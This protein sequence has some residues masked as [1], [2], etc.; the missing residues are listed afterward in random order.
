MIRPS[1]HCCSR[2]ITGYLNLAQAS[3]ESGSV[4]D[5]RLV[6]ENVSNLLPELSERDRRH[7][8]EASSDSPGQI[9]PRANSASNRRNH[10]SSHSDFRDVTSCRCFRPGQRLDKREATCCG[11]GSGA[12][13]GSREPAGPASDAAAP[14]LVTS[15]MGRSKTTC[16]CAS[17]PVT[18]TTSRTARSSSTRNAAVTAG[19]RPGRAALAHRTSQP[20]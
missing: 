11:G 13:P 6:L 8:S 5:T 19:A 1:M 3:L 7:H 16:A 9:R 12:A 4:A 17:M 10:E 2:A 14:W 20:A 15:P 18:T